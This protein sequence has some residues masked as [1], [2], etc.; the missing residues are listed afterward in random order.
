MFTE[1]EICLVPCGG[2]RS[3]FSGLWKNIIHPLGNLDSLS[4]AYSSGVGFAL[5]AGDF[6][7]FWT[8]DWTEVGLLNLKF[9]RIFAL[10]VKKEGKV[11]EFGYFV[12]NSWVWNIPLRRLLF[13]WEI[14]QWNEFQAAIS[15]FAVNGGAEDTIVWKTFY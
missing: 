14:A 5:G 3:F 7:D 1:E 8:D 2:R 13:D 10:A 12:N 15:D 6:I 9:P 11:K 4:S